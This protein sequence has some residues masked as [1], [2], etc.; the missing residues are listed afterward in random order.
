MPP[1]RPAVPYPC[2]LLPTPA[3]LALCS[4]R[5]TGLHLSA[6]C[7]WLLSAAMDGTL[8]VWDVPA[9]T[10]LQVGAAGGRGERKRTRKAD[11]VCQERW[12]ERGR[13]SQVGH[14]RWRPGGPLNHVDVFLWA[15]A[16]L[17]CSKGLSICEMRRVVYTVAKRTVKARTASQVV[18]AGRH[19]PAPVLRVPGA[20]DTGPLST[21]PLCAPCVGAQAGR[22]R[23]Q[24]QPVPRAGPAGHH[25]RQQAGDIPVVKPG[26]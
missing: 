1:G 26:G 20:L 9:A 3:L 16:S 10:C 2:R 13:C 5:I 4:D 21:R 19:E 12:A 14:C 25:T 6:D 7:R 24:P 17:C 15:R 18:L 11:T 8:R 23:D 22:P